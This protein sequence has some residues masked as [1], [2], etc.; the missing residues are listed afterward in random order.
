MFAH[1]EWVSHMH[2]AYPTKYKCRVALPRR[3]QS[4]SPKLSYR[5]GIRDFR[6]LGSHAASPKIEATKNP[7]G[8]HAISPTLLHRVT[9]GVSWETLSAQQ[10][11]Y[12]ANTRTVPSI[13]T[14]L[15]VFRHIAKFTSGLGYRLN[16]LGRIDIRDIATHP[17]GHR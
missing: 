7:R 11:H 3:D 9:C 1:D 8:P 14:R 15:F 6:K 12:Y 17:S 16:T 4:V 2:P 13:A 10:Q 5:Q